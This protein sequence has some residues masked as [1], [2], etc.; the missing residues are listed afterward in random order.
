MAMKVL[1][2]GDTYTHN[3]QVTEAPVVGYFDR[4]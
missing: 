4:V 2:L 3:G 1:T